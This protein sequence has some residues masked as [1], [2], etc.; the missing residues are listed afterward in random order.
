M[1]LRADGVTGTRAAVEGIR[2]L[3]WFVSHDADTGWLRSQPQ[4]VIVVAS[5]G[6]GLG[7]DQGT[8]RLSMGTLAASGSPRPCSAK[9]DELISCAASAARSSILIL[10][11]ADALATLERK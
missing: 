10:S 3:P 8:A 9:F 7:K 11:Q 2:E 4:E 5:G 1:T 6:L